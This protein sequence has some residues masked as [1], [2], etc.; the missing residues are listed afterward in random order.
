MSEKNYGNE[1]EFFGVF[2]K[3][4]ERDQIGEKKREIMKVNQL[5]IGS[6]LSYMQMAISVMI[7]LVYTPIMLRLLGKSEYG[8][9][10]TVASTISMMSILSLGFNSSYIRYYSKYK[11]KGDQ[12]SI[13]RLNGLFFGIFTVIGAIA[14]I[15]GLFLT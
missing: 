3:I 5:K 14:L 1:K 4:F 2:A 13:F 6:L 11:T 15:C 8:L 9:Y 10:N 7:G 12:E